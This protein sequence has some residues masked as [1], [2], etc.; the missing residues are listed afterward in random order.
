[1]FGGVVGGNATLGNLS[2]IGDTI[3]FSGNMSGTGNLTIQPSTTSQAINLN[4]GSSGLYLT[5][6]E[7]GYI[8][9]DWSGVVI[10]N[11][12]DTG[13]MTLGAATWAAP[14]SFITKST[15]NIAVTGER[16]PAIR[17]FLLPARP[18]CRLM[19]P[20]PASGSSTAAGS[21]SARRQ[22]GQ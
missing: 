2:I 14:T 9:N 21:R 4:N 6:T 17:R 3:S 1:M 8:Q 22:H 20:T 15:G 12:N 7:I 10:G 19:S 16:R 13:T 18:P 5:T 11:A